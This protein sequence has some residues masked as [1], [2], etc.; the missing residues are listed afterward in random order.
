MPFSR[1]PLK[2]SEGLRIEVSYSFGNPV[3][4]S[5]QVSSERKV[6]ILSRRTGDVNGDRNV[7]LADY[8]SALAFKRSGGITLSLA[9]LAQAADL[10]AAERL[11][12]YRVADVAASFG[13]IDESDANAILRKRIVPI[14]VEYYAAW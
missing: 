2:G 11:I 7:N 3:Y 8:E 14:S 1:K 13:K 12:L 9:E 6:V 4:S 5:S 10:S